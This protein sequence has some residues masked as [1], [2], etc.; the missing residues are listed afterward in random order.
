[1]DLA[2]FS[3][4]KI[5]KD[6]VP[7]AQQ[8]KYSE[9]GRLGAVARID[10][11]LKSRYKNAQIKGKGQQAIIVLGKAKLDFDTPL[12]V[13]IGA[14]I[15]SYIVKEQEQGGIRPHSLTAWKSIVG[16]G[17]DYRKV[18]SWIDDYDDPDQR[19]FDDTT[20]WKGLTATKDDFDN[21]VKNEFEK[22]F[23]KVAKRLGSKAGTVT[24]GSAIVETH[25]Q[26]DGR[27]TYKTVPQQLDGETLDKVEVLKDKLKTKYGTKRYRHTKDWGDG[28]FV[29]GLKQVWEAYMINDLGLGIDNLDKELE[30]VKDYTGNKAYKALEKTGLSIWTLLLKEM[31]KRV[32]AKDKDTQSKLEARYKA[33]KE[34]KEQV[35]LGI[36]TKEHVM[37]ILGSDYLV[38]AKHWG[39]L[40]GELIKAYE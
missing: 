3:K 7:P 23:K 34:L 6:L 35:D 22:A 15:V 28:L 13:M 19:L 33:S 2:S 14:G 12:Q 27:T 16:I 21:Y 8:R 29:L 10:K 36:L 24:M 5:F 17:Y 4:T 1:M 25:K 38:T 26:D 20:D 9:T 30:Q 39:E 18:M 32:E 40:K 31:G 37:E 11:L